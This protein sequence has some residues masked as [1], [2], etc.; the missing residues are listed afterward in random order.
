MDARAVRLRVLGEI[1]R[2]VGFDAYAWPLT[3]PETAVGT[4]PL[5]DVPCLPELPRL[6]RL[7]YLT[8]TNRWTTLRPG[9]VTTLRAATGGNPARSL[10]WREMLDGYGVADVASAVFADRFGVWAFLDLWRSRPF[11]GPETATLTRILEPVTTELRRAQAETFVA[12]DGHSPRPGPVVL[13]LSPELDVLGHTPDT[14]EYLRVLVPPDDGRAPVPAGAYNVAAQLLANE[15]GVDG[16]RPAARVHLADGRWVTLRAARIVRDIAVTIEESAPAERVA[17]F[18]RAFGLSTRERELLGHLAHGSDTRDLARR[19]FL[20][21][22]TVQDHLKSIF[23][24]TAVRN[25]RTLLAR[26]LGG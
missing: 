2:K 8:P 1:R 15:A 14:A 20:S 26:A 18:G 23:T 13:L 17:L 6:I 24:K 21:E 25:R 19:M 22:H 16:H 12:R 10:L 5:A 9:T 11:T 4:A 7:K 3:D